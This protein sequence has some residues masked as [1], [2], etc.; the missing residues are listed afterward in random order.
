VERLIIAGA[1]VVVAGAVAW[2]LNRRRPDPPT[3]DRVAVPAQLDRN[4]FARPDS[5]WLL[6][7]FTSTTCE[8]CERATAKA[9]VMESRFLAY[10][11]IPWQTRRDLHERYA[12]DTVPLI[13]IAD[14]DGVVQRSFVGT[15][16]FTHLAAAV[17]EAREPGSTPE[18]EV[19]LL[20]R[21]AP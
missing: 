3:Q 8:S 12:I 1:L 14:S 10:E 19:G 11:E 20:Q 9:R 5:P 6:A 7:V 2:V 15:P 13:V 4:D 21:E 18:P 16:S 17:A